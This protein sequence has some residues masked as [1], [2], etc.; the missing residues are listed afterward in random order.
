MDEVIEACTTQAECIPGA[1]GYLD[2]QFSDPRKPTQREQLSAKRARL[3]AQL[4][5]VNAALAALD[6]NPQLERFLEVM[7]RA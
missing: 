2:K 5:N 6:E 1:G 4:A 7:A 3:S